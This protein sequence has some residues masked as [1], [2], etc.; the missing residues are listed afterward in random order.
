LSSQDYWRPF[1]VKSDIVE[2][3][4]FIEIDRWN[5]SLEFAKYIL[6]FHLSNKEIVI[7]ENF[8]LPYYD[9]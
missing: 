2:A 6:N 1:E 4:K 5:K 8:E 9:C 7:Y 3:E